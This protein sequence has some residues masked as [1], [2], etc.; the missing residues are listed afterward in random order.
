VSTRLLQAGWDVRYQPAAVFHHLKATA[1]RVPGAGVMR[2]RVRNQLWYCWL[3][4]PID[5][6]IVRMAGY[7]VFDLVEAAYR[8]ALASWAGGIAD[9]WRQR[10][11]I[12][13]DRNPVP[14]QLVARVECGRGR[15]HVRLL[16]RQL[17]RR[18]PGVGRQPVE[19]AGSSVC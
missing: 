5:K 17:L 4:F 13:G 7:L 10:D 19:A 12:R 8:G 1:G 18:L 16:V 15:L 6:A 3:R 2:Y 11:Q 9:A 14:R